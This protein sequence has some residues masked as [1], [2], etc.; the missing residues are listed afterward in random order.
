MLITVRKTENGWKTK[1]SVVPKI[2]QGPGIRERKKESG[3]SLKGQE[4]KK[5]ETWPAR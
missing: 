4:N 3:W 1:V 5:K 2:C